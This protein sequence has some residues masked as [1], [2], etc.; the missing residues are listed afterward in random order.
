MQ[1]QFPR[2]Y[3]GH[4]RE[5]EEV[6]VTKDLQYLSMINMS[7]SANLPDGVNFFSKLNKEEGNGSASKS[8]SG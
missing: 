1:S 2:D 5:K 4:S 6:A 8:E 3:P 7:F